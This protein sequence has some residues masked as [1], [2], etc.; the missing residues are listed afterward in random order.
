MAGK[1]ETVGSILYDIK[2]IKEINKWE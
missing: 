2:K 1:E